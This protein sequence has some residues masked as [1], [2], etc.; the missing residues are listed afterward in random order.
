MDALQ[1]ETR[2]SVVPGGPHACRQVR[3]S[4]PDDLMWGPSWWKGVGVLNGRDLKLVIDVS[5]PTDR[6]MSST[7]LDLIVY[8]R[9]VVAAIYVL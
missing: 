6:Q 5:V 9:R 7:R 8:S 3:Y 2:Q 4:I 1:R